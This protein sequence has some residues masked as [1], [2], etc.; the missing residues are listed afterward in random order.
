M[1]IFLKICN[2]DIVDQ[3][4]LNQKDECKLFSC[5]SLAILWPRLT[6][7]QNRGYRWLSSPATHLLRAAG[8]TKSVHPKLFL[9]LAIFGFHINMHPPKVIYI[10]INYLQ[11]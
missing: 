5:A 7:H 8:Y 11:L 10:L 3:P 4:P 6:I 9:K 1:G 2:L